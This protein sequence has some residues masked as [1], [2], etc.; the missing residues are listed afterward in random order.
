MR[1][2]HIRLVLYIDGILVTSKKIG[3]KLLL[4]NHILTKIF[5]SFIGTAG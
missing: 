2:E 4:L 5:F 1:S 3:V